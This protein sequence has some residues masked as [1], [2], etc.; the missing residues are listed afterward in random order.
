MD[1]MKNAAE[2]IQVISDYLTG[3]EGK[4]AFL[5]KVGLLDAA[6]LFEL[7]AAEVCRLW[8]GQ[9]FHNLNMGKANFPA[10]DLV[11]EDGQIYVQ[12]STVQDV[13]S[14][15]KRTLQ[16]SVKAIRSKRFTGK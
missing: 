4:I 14:K 11:S 15:I 1:V 3:Y 13:S 6:T 9:D 8:F 10:V 7:F 2:R 5:N 12:V 16:K